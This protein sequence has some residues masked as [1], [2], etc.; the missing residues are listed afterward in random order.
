M[1]IT[2]YKER[3]MYDDVIPLV[4]KHHKELLE[5]THVHLAKVR[6]LNQGGR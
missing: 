5:E 6:A 1:A 2:M 4:A 3:K